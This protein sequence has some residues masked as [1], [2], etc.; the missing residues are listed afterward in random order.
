MS[1]LDDAESGV[2]ARLRAERDRLGL[3]QEA[4][5]TGAGKNKQTQ[6]RY[7]TGLNS[8]T[9]AYLHNLVPLGVDIGY[10]L[11]GFP[12]ELRDDE[13]ELLGRYRSASP[14]LRRAALSV[15][16]SGQSAP[17]PAGSVVMSGSNHGQVN[18]GPVTQGA[19]SFQ[20]GAAPVET[21]KKKTTK[22]RS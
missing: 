18:A 5:G 10:V 22:S 11:T 16:G 1:I 6:L 17:S 12:S 15:L 13:A 14:E 3:S 20:V 2:G 21:A 9:A 7:E 4:M 19:V 8:P